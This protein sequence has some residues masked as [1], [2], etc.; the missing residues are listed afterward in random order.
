MPRPK[1][2]S[3]TPSTTE[4]ITT[5]ATITFKIPLIDPDKVGEIISTERVADKLVVKMK[6]KAIIP[7][8]AQGDFSVS[9]D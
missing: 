4:V 8:S 6:V 9:F 5:A 2:L 1:I 3:S 7:P